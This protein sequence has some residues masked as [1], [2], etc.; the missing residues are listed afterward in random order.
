MAEARPLSSNL[1]MW[2]GGITLAA[3]NFVVVLDATV[4][5][6]SVPHIA[7]SLAIAPDQGTWVITSYSVAEAICVPLTGWLVERFGAVKSF[8]CCMVGFAICSLL[9]GLSVSLGMLVASRVAQGFCGGPLMPL[10]QTLLVRIFPAEK[11]GAA[12]GMWAMTLVTAP[13]AGPLLGGAI[14]DGWSWHWIFFINVPIVAVCVTS[15]FLL[16]RGAE[17]PI[18]KTRIDFVGLGALALWVGALQI[19]LDIGRDH[20]W[21]GSTLVCGL[22]VVAAIGFAFFVIWELSAEQ[23]IVDLRVFRHRGFTFSVVALGLTFG[24]YFAAVVVT[25]QWLQGAMGYTA[26][27]AGKTVAWSG[28]FAVILSPFVG[29]LIGRGIDAR[30]LISCGTLWVAFTMA[31]RAHWNADADYW[32]LAVPHMLVGIGMPFFIV[33]ITMLALSSV[34][35]R[36]TA[37]AAGMS[38]FVRTLSSAIFTSIATTMWTDREQI[39]RA[40]LANIIQPGSAYADMLARHGVDASTARGML[41]NLVDGQAVALA[42][43]QLYQMATVVLIAAAVMVWLVPKPKR[44]AA[45]GGAH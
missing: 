5:N 23:P 14:S 37:S 30:L 7:G 8:I 15:A 11:R 6:V 44:I 28:L 18:L 3:S 22:G 41:S 26:T 42:T 16:L 33:P 1:L 12:M 4:A 19:M 29:R 35:P 21:F 43:T 24:T 34:D 40:D 2:L 39:D 9:C 10:T 27:W 45:A 20:D 25:P 38:S 31:L 36:E 13:I 32:T 17:T